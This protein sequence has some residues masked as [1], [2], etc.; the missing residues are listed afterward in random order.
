[1]TDATDLLLLA[2]VP[3]PDS[4]WQLQAG[5]LSA[6]VDEDDPVWPLL[7]AYYDFLTTLA[8]RATS[9]EFSHFASLL[10]MGAVG[11][12]ALQNIMLA[13][14]EGH[15]W[16]RLLA[17]GL[18]EGLMVMAARQYVRAWEGE[19]EAVFTAAR[20]QLYRE[21]WRISAALR[22]ALPTAERSRLLE[23]LVAPL[24]DH[25]LE[26]TQRAALATRLYQLL[27]LARVRL[28]LGRLAEAP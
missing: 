4:L 5:L 28:A 24:A 18:S 3:M 11:G 9:R 16:T 14:G 21:L 12:V 15:W 2:A 25:N 27:L 13:E 22:P 26:G 23:Y 19:M 1:V 10:D 6:R 20:W 17:G 7:D 8:V